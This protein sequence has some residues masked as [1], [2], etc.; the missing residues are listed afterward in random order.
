MKI[1]L[2]RK[3][4]PSLPATAILAFKWNIAHPPPSVF[5]AD[6]CAMCSFLIRTLWPELQ[7]HSIP[8]GGPQHQQHQGL[9]LEHFSRK[10]NC[11]A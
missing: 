3:A 6:H 5:H 8:M 1:Y 4:Y 10:I 9:I 7:A 11:E 2:D